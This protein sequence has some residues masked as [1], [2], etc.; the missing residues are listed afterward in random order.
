MPAILPEPEPHV[1]VKQTMPDVIKDSFTM[2]TPKEKPLEIVIPMS[3]R[4][5]SGKQLI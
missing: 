3:K 4:A 2:E 5:S 1:I